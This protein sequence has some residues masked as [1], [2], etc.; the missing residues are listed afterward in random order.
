MV[1]FMYFFITGIGVFMEKQ[2]TCD[3]EKDK[4]GVFR[5]FHFYFFHISY[6]ISFGEEIGSF[7]LA[8]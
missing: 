3:C 7:E 1:F 2:K 8:C 5:R 4:G 6:R